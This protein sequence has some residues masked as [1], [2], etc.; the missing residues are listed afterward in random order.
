[1]ALQA[2]AGGGH[3]TALGILL[4]AGADV[5]ALP[6]KESG[7]TASQAA[8]KG[9]HET[10][11]GILLKAGADVNAPPGQWSGL[12]ALQEQQRGDMTLLSKYCSRP[13]PM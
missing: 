13:A 8:A 12:T 4:K 3:E 1:M 10:A 6:G 11:L 5:N 7:L 9:G 2:A